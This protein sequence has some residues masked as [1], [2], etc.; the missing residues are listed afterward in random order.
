MRPATQNKRDLKKAREHLGKAHQLITAA[1]NLM[2]GVEKRE[3]EQ[4][5]STGRTDA[6]QLRKVRRG[7]RHG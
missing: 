7:K 3:H 6:S 5:A 1:W 4:H 2:I